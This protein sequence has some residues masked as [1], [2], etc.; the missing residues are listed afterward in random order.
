MSASACGALPAAAEG[1]RA[2]RRSL[3]PTAWA[4]LADLC[5]DAEPAGAGAHVVATS[6]RRV[7][8]HLGISKDTAARALRRLIAAGVVR[9]RPQDAGIAGRFT[10]GSYELRVPLPLPATPCRPDE[11]TVG[12]AR[13]KSAETEPVAIAVSPAKATVLATPAHRR[14]RTSIG[15][16]SGQLSLLDP[17]PVDAGAGDVEPSR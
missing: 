13:R 9:R 12:S 15:P 3:G 7:G 11:D 17:A 16:D 5:L 2:L 1:E 8:A 10:S 6:A 14:I 4:V